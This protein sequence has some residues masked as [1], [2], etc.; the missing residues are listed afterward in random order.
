MRKTSHR[1]NE[2]VDSLAPWERMHVGSKLQARETGIVKE[3]EKNNAEGTE[4]A[5][6]TVEGWQVQRNAILGK[7]STLNVKG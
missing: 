4:P 5:M 7:C 2:I 6:L 3:V 1:H